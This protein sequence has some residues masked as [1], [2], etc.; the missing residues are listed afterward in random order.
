MN[1]YGIDIS[2]FTFLIVIKIMMHKILSIGELLLRFESVE[3]SNTSSNNIFAS[4]PG[5]SEANVAVALSTLDIPVSYFTVIPDNSLAENAIDKIQDTGVDTSS[6]L[7]K[8]GRLG[9]YFLQDPN[10][11]TKGE[12][13]YDRKY[14]SFYSVE[15]K[16]IDWNSIFGDCTW[17]HWTAIT[18]ALSD[19]WAHLMKQCLDEAKKQNLFISVDLNYRNKLWNY[20]KFPLEIMPDLVQSCDLIMGNIWASNKMLGTSITDE[21]NRNTTKKEYFIYAQKVSKELFSIYPKCKHIANTF[22]FMDNS[23]HNLLYGTYHTPKGNWQS[24]SLETNVLVD[25]IGSGDAFMSG[26]IFAICKEYSPQETIDFATS[27][28]FKKLFIKGDFY[29]KNNITL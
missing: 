13:I 23:N 7:K 11:L 15:E 19:K 5:G 1:E 28:G 26:L 2:N 17:L 9:L 10:G 20:G 24:E 4:Y 16:E 14:S 12:V 22:R 18:P 29:Q 27:I 25:R 21:L 6:I 8:E 3:N